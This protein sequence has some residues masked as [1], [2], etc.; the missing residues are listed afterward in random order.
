MQQLQL[1]LSLDQV[2]ILL[3]GLDYMPYG[4]AAPV[5][6]AIHAQAGQQLPSEKTPEEPVS[7]LQVAS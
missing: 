7:D 5:V 3:Q 2:N 4:Q 1:N 6:Q